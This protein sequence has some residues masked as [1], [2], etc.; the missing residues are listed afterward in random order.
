MLRPVSPR[1]Q[2]GL[3]SPID[4]H[5]KQ[6]YLLLHVIHHNLSAEK[7]PLQLF[8]TVPAGCGKTFIIKLIL[9]IHNR[10]SDNDDFYNSY[11]ICA[12]TGKTAVAINGTPV[13]TALKISLSNLI[14]LSIETAQQY[15]C[16]F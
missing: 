12:L 6:K 5:Q 9:E 13:H 16:L 4:S 2:T 1:Q 3:P 11:I 15:R 8:F 10:F 7:S 14:P